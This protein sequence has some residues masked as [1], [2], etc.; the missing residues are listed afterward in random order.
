MAMLRKLA[1]D[2]VFGS[3]CLS[4]QMT[5]V[6]RCLPD[7]LQHHTENSRRRPTVGSSTLAQSWA[8]LQ[9]VPDRSRHR[10]TSLINRA[11]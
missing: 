2:L 1:S 11:H 5:A 3:A 9:A 7:S 4:S 10:I 8:Y 6:L